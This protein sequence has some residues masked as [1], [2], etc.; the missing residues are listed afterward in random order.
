MAV[1]YPQFPLARPQ[2]ATPQMSSIIN[3]AIPNF[4]RLNQN[5][6]GIIENLMGGMPSTGPARNKGA[7]FGATSGMPNSG[8]SNALGYDLYRQDSDE[9]QQRGLDNFLKLIQ[10]YSGTV[11]PTTGQQNQASQYQEDFN[12]QRRQFD[13]SRQDAQA[14]L[15]AANRPRIPG[16]TYRITGAGGGGGA[17]GLNNL[18]TW[19]P[20]WNS[21]F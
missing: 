18:P 2:A 4:S 11:M 1:Q 9:Y 5:A 17:F 19:N 13:L 7:Y 15:A 14:R 21:R 12:E 8:V 6:S 3:N 20:A 16:G 10:G